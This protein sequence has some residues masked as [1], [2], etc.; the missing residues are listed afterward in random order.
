MQIIKHDCFK[1]LEEI[2]LE[3]VMPELILQQEL[4]SKLS[5]RVDCVKSDVEIRMRSN[6]AEVLAQGIPDTSPHKTNTPHI[7][8]S[9]L[10][11]SLEWKLARIIRVLEFIFGNEA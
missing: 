10:H 5:Q 11:E 7:E 4:I 2:F 6:D 1:R 8:V 3:V 9:H